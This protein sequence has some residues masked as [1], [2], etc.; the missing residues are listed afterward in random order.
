MFLFPWPNSVLLLPACM[1][2]L[3]RSHFLAIST[4][5]LGILSINSSALSLFIALSRKGVLIRHPFEVIH[6]FQKPGD[7]APLVGKMEKR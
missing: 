6:R 7:R 1:R 2:F 5:L 3:Y 4:G